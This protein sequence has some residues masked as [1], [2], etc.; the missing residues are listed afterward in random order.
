MFEIYGQGIFK[1]QIVRQAP[2]ISWSFFLSIFPFIL[3][4]LSIIPI[5]P[6]YEEVQHYIFDVLLENALPGNLN[7][8]KKYIINS[9]MPT[10]NRIGF[11]T[12]LLV[13]IFAS[14]GT[15][16]LIRGFNENLDTKRGF[17]KEFSIALGITVAF[18]TIISASI[19]GIYYAEVVFKYFR[20]IE[21]DSWLMQNLTE[22][23]GYIYFP[24]FYC[25]LLTLFYW[26]GCMKMRYFKEAIPGAIFTTILFT[27]STYIFIN[28]VP[29]FAHQNILYGSIGSI[30]LMMIW[31]NV[32]VVL[33]LLGN[34]LNIAI[35]N[36]ILEN[37]NNINGNNHVI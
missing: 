6:H 34:E 7:D 37:K 2:G 22:A 21:S 17:V 8:F 23:I 31:V 27:I 32:N 26:A 11:F 15:Y 4:L 14:N 9:I 3:F 12:V 16:T 29:Y 13:L 10:T 5:L 33:I 20:P 25:F 19:L 24:I 1:N 35:K 36:Q 18:V 28:Y 30:M